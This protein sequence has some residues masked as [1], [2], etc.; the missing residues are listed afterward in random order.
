MAKSKPV[1]EQQAVEYFIAQAHLTNDATGRE[2]EAGETVTSRDFEPE[3]I[4][5]WLEIGVLVRKE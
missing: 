3:V 1:E 4:T 2:Y 5:N